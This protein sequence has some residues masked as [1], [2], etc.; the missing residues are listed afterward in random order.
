MQGD[1]EGFGAVAVRDLRSGKA[2]RHEV[3]RHEHD[4]KNGQRKPRPLVPK[5]TQGV[6][7]HLG[8]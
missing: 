4:E 3:P 2:R 7:H 6:A 1:D 5:Q 8:R